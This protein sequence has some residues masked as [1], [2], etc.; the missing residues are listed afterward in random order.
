VLHS[1]DDVAANRTKAFGGKDAMIENFL[2]VPGSTV[3]E[4]MQ[5]GAWEYRLLRAERL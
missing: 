4:Q 5:S 1:C 3:Y 2:A